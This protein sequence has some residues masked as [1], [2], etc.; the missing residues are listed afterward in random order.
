MPSTPLHAATTASLVALM[1][2]RASSVHRSL[3]S[4]ILPAAPQLVTRRSGPS[5][6]MS[7]VVPASMA[8]VTW[9]SPD[10]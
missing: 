9:S 4:S 3:R 1:S 6:M 2:A 5:M 7:G 8:L 10:W